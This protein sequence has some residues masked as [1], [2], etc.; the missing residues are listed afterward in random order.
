[1]LPP[2]RSCTEADAPG[3]WRN[4]SS[5]RIPSGSGPQLC[6][7]HNSSS[8]DSTDSGY[9]D[10]PA[11]FCGRSTG[12]Y[13]KMTR[14]DYED[15][16]KLVGKHF[17][18]KFGFAP[19]LQD[20]R[21][22]EP[23]EM[24][25]A[26]R[27]KDARLQTLKDELNSVK[28]KLDSYNLNDWHKHTRAM[29]KAGEI[30]WRL[31]KEL[32]PEFLTQAWCKFYENARSFILVPPTVVNTGCLSSVH[33]CEAP[34][35]FITSLNHFLKLHNPGIEWKWLATTLNPYY[36]G[37]PLS[38]MINDDRFILQTLS[39]WN[40]GLDYTGNL[41]DLNN[42]LHLVQEAAKIG[43]VLLVTADG[44]IDCQEDPGE[45][46]SLVASL[47]YCETVSAL[48][49]LAQGGSFLLKMFTMY[50][51]ETV[52]L[53]FLLC[54]A[55]NRV[56]VFKPAT[57]KEGNSEVYVVCLEYRGRDV[58]EPWLEVLRK[59]FGPELPDKAVF[60]QASIPQ[61]FLDQLYK[62]ASLFKDLQTDVIET[63]IQMYERGRIHSQDYKIKRLRYLIAN[64]FMETYEIVKLPESDE[65]VGKSKLKKTMTLNMDPRAEEGSFADRRKKSTLK[66]LE[67]LTVLNEELDSM[68]VVWP[69][70]D[71]DVK[72]LEFPTCVKGFKIQI[73]QPVK[74]VHSSK[75]C[76]GRLLRIRNQ[77]RE[78]ARRDFQFSPSTEN[79]IS[80]KNTVA[81]ERLDLESELSQQLRK[82]YP[83]NKLI[84]LNYKE[85][86]WTSMEGGNEEAERNAFWDI[87]DAIDNMWRDENLLL[88]GYP[89][90]TQFNVGIVY[91][92]CHLFDEVGFVKP[93]KQDFAVLFVGF[94]KWNPQMRKFLGEVDDTIEKLHNEGGNRTVL[95]LFPI[96]MLC[97]RYSSESKTGEETREEAH[98]MQNGDRYSDRPED[99]D[100]I[101]YKCVT[102]VN[103]LCVKEQVSDIIIN[104]LKKHGYSNV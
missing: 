49:I 18:K 11:A 3:S 70:G 103:H 55:F 51:H 38:C 94:R 34:G 69:F 28:S 56:H 85:K 75:F 59:H 87:M 46:E 42:M 53:M 62:C 17:D 65:V 14:Q 98:G 6:K 21:L 72:H 4:C 48:H 73:G 86:L 74:T 7:G 12:R 32:E 93:V 33:L 91:M 104:I 37:N 95:S 22:P 31:R 52:C 26:E 78:I 88:Q 68:R 63:N 77:V 1:M 82:A 15:F 92:L 19:P 23:S 2:I 99:H 10:M 80:C 64:H 89:M 30:Q 79:D 29:N 96:N 41:M 83:K 47:H 76:L 36:E 16:E 43:D 20:W 84:I 35:A 13:E 54:C 27:W 66:P 90:L 40:F 44:S 9:G 45:Q 8:S 97:E 67:L 58:I 102:E 71:E 25:V 101:F 60:P 50:E 100:N 81:S 5:G 61:D 24:F 57:S 39:N